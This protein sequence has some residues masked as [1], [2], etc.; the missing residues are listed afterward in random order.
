M[1]DATE[2]ISLKEKVGYGFGDT[3]SNL[4]FQTFMVYLM[5][6][7]TDVFG[8]APAVA[9][10]M[11]AVTR[12]GDTVVEP[13]VGVLA[14]RTK[15]RWGKFRPYLIWFAI[16]YGVIGFLTFSTP[17]FGSQGKVFYAYATYS[18]M[19]VVY[20][21][22]N[23]PYSALMGVMSGN[24]LERTALASARFVG[25]FAGGLMVKATLKPLIATLGAGNEARGAQLVAALYAVLAIVLFSTTFA[26]TKERV[27]PPPQ[28]KTSL[29]NDLGD[30]LTN[31]PWMVL[32]FVGIAMLSYVAVRNS[33]LAYYVKYYVGNADRKFWIWDLTTWFW[34]AGAVSNIIGVL[35][36]K[37]VTKYVG[38]KRLFMLIMVASSLLTVG[39]YA[40]KPTDIAA[41]FAVEITINL[42]M[43]PASPL[44]WA[45]YADTAD[46]SEW[47]TGRR[48][49]GL[50]FSA[51]S[52]AQK[53]GW[54][55][56][57]A[58]SGWLLAYFDFKPNIT[59]APQALEGIR[60][61][62]S[63]LP[64]VGSILAVVCM[65]VYNLDESVV[66]QMEKELS[67]RRAKDATQQAGALPVGA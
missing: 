64:A 18:A 12:L 63:F 17:N 57:G 53:M 11:L 58:L 26:T 48:A 41:M 62:M 7:Y 52:F 47:K 60:L 15:T 55:V 3:A 66:Q 30:L 44:I 10:T 37:Y 38:K 1:S 56:G 19:M 36:T 51:A 8:L 54:T 24:S 65:A 14:D 6:F 16:P 13:I 9:G 29:R 59:Q 61:M 33:T 45:M 35:L 25:A 28:Q 22:I 50:I 2:K 31:R 39:F 27:Q 23:I 5:I 34:V 43:G 46:Y 49:T 4:F 40:F 32:F 42:I 67:E 21:L 20:S